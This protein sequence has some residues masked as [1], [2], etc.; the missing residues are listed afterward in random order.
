M[1]FLTAYNKKLQENA[2]PNIITKPFICDPSL[3][4]LTERLELKYRYEYLEDTVES[5]AI[6]Y[7][8]SPKNTIDWLEENGAARKT[9]ETE[10]EIQEFEVYVNKLYKSMQIRILGLTAFNTVKSCQALI[11]A[12]EDILQSLKTASKALGSLEYPDPKTIAALASTHSKLLSGHALIQKITE[13][14]G[15]IETSIDKYPEW[16][17]EVTHMDFQPKAKKEK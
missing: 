6:H 17:M 13:T 8:L 16:E 4:S 5:L 7:G 15:D 2:E 10:E 9:L 3:L 12:E 1:D 11:A 14:A